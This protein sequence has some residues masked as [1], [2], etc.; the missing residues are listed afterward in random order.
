MRSHRQLAP[1]P[2]SSNGVTARRLFAAGAILSTALSGC[3]AQRVLEIRSDPSEC[4]VRIDG[5]RVGATPLELP[6]DHYGKRRVTIYRE[7]YRTYSR[8]VDISA[9]W[10]GTF[11]L[12]IVSEVLFPFGWKDIHVV[13]AKLQPGVAVLLEPDLQDVLD[14]A[15]AMRRAGPDGP[16]DRPAPAAVST[17]RARTDSPKP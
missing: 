13:N 6:F 3:R 16:K 11:P 1:R 10:Y 7:G 12:D 2:A 9:P 8:I 17:Q 15:E 14:R 5:E 4:E